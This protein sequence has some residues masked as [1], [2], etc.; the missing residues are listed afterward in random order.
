MERG[1]IVMLFATLDEQGVL[2]EKTHGIEMGREGH[3]NIKYLRGRGAVGD[4]QVKFR[5]LIAIFG[6]QGAMG[7]SHH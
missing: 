1:F 5:P 3:S 2:L 4:W 6:I 7:V